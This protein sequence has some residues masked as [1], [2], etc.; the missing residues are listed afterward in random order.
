MVNVEFCCALQSSVGQSVE[1]TVSV[2]EKKCGG[3][4]SRATFSRPV[5]LVSVVVVA[6]PPV[7]VSGL[8]SPRQWESLQKKE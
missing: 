3:K 7:V 4:I 1:N 6:G 5:S 8:R 2:E